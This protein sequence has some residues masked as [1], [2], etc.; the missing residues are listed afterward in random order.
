[1]VSQPKVTVILTSFNHAKYLRESIE[2][3]LAQTYSDFELIIGDDASSDESWEIINSYKDLRIRAFR[4]EKTKGGFII[5]EALSEREIREYVAIHHSDDVWEPDK[6]EK[7]VAFLNENPEVGA[8]FTWA[9]I[10]DEDGN[11]LTDESHFYYKIFE[12]PNRSKYEWLNYFFY[13]GNALCHPSVLIR[14][15]CYEE[16]GVYRPGL[17][18][19]GDFDMWVRLAL[20]HEIHIISEKLVRFRVRQNKTNSSSDNQTTRVRNQF[21]TLQL[22]NHYRDIPSFQELKAIFPEAE[23]YEKGG[24][25][26]IGFILGLIALKETAHAFTEIFGLTL[27]FE[28]INDPARAK[29]L[30]ELYDF[31]QLDFI[32]LSAE[33]DVFST[34]LTRNL[35]VQVIDLETQMA[36]LE[37]Q[38]IH[39]DA[40]TIVL[41]EQLQA[42]KS[43]ETWRILMF[44]HE[45]R[46][47]I[48]HPDILQTVKKK[49]VSL[50]LLP[51][52]PFRK[53]V[54][55][56]NR[57]ITLPRMFIDTAKE[58]GV[59]FSLKKV[60]AK[61]VQF[62]LR[63]G[64]PVSINLPP[65][66]SPIENGF[67]FISHDA[68]ATGAPISLLSQCRAY[69]EVY[70]DDIV[71]VLFA[72]GAL[73]DE[74]KSVGTTICFEQ[75]LSS[76]VVNEEVNTVFAKLKELGYSNCIANTVISGALSE[77]LNANYIET[78]YQL[79]EL[80]GLIRSA[81]YV[82]YAKNIAKSN[83]YI[84]CAANYVAEKFIETFGA[85][86]DSICVIPQGVQASMLYD[87]TKE[88][89]KAKLLAKLQLPYSDDIKIVLGAGVA[90][91]RKGTDLFFRVTERLH[92]MGDGD[93]IHF[94]WVGARDDFYEH[95]KRKILPTLPYKK[96]I[97][98]LDFENDPA[99][100]FAGADLFLL[101]SREDPYPSVAIISIAN[102]TPILMFKNT[103]GIEEILNGTNG[104]AVGHL[105]THEMA[106]EAL[107]I[108]NEKPKGEL[109]K[110]KLITY[111]DYIKA[112]VSLIENKKKTFL[113][114]YK[115]SVIVPN[116]NYEEY[117]AARLQ[118]IIEQTYPPAEIIF[119]DDVSSDNSVA[120]AKE[121]LQNSN[122]PYKVLM[123]QENQGAF[124]QW[125]KGIH[126]AKYEYIWIAEA[127]DLAAKDFLDTL[128]KAFQNK[129]TVLAYCQPMQIDEDSKPY[130][131]Y[132]YADYVGKL[133]ETRWQTNYID[134]GIFEITNYLSVQNTIP[135]VSGV[136]FKK[137]SLKGIEDQLTKYK[138][139]G[140]WFA[141]LYA[142]RSG[143]I[144][145]FSKIMNF[146]RRHR[147]SIITAGD[148]AINFFKEIAEIYDYITDNFTINTRVLDMMEAN[149][150][151]E[152]NAE[153]A[154]EIIQEALKGLREKHR[155]ILNSKKPFEIIIIL[156]EFQIGGGEIT[157]LRLANYLANDHNVYLCA[158]KPD[159]NEQFLEMV[160]PKIHFIGYDR[161]KLLAL[162]RSGKIDIVNSHIWWA[163]KLAYSLLKE[164]HIFW[165][166]SM[167]G[168]YE[169]LIDNPE[170]DRTFKE[171]H[172][173]M[174]AR[175]DFI[176]Y[177][178]A[179]NLMALKALKNETLTNK[180]RLI[181]HG[182]EG[183]KL[184]N[185]VSKESLG[186]AEDSF[187][188]VF[189]ARGIKE[190]GWEE[191]IQSSIS[192]KKSGYNISVILVGDSDYVQK[193]RE[194]YAL[195]FIKFVGKQS[196]LP[197]YFQIADAGLLPTYFVS[198]SQPLIIIEYLAAGLP[199]ISTDI[200]EIK[201]MLHLDGAEAGIVLPL[202]KGRFLEDELEK[203]MKS[204]LLDKENYERL[205][206]TT[207]KIF[208]TKFGIEKFAQA[209][210]SLYIGQESN[211]K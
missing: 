1:M 34:E 207:K 196:N 80:P 50:A 57:V 33:N 137:G 58:Y 140:D 134:D 160:S 141:Y 87:G 170:V 37:T 135:N 149:L 4:H 114:E 99:Y 133:S 131:E 184:L 198:E 187:V 76:I 138:Y 169:M 156:A 25:E 46:T 104:K 92:E 19:I 118:S 23:K 154:E 30:K 42:I 41:E 204:L 63:S 16:C 67:I 123:N 128:L 96:N 15:E 111:T 38:A 205:Q 200:G 172:P 84:V 147:K 101:S 206:Q 47:F 166:L 54:S 83:S 9:N 102:N 157:G 11:P 197:D 178:T 66:L 171:Q 32:K 139:A 116:Y 146:H 211:S 192:M 27:V 71:I 5:N 180:T 125:L 177:D 51:K 105:N 109:S 49:L 112:T 24:R 8:V 209:Y 68:S 12:Q 191:T 65:N 35:L 144:A 122:I 173:S 13:Q 143:Q 194:K 44:L 132:R 10:I 64:K 176:T 36:R 43:S 69:K 20:K 61:I 26:D 108:L 179:K 130:P 100:I 183:G 89:A 136:V 90:H 174:Y 148:G 199:V 127:D 208:D 21:E 18:Q 74:F 150:R 94:L 98:F 91:K 86:E 121:I 201:N 163:D 73:L 7:Q 165:I 97:H 115:V 167:H 72:G 168:C 185:P 6:L 95:W 210:L 56:S 93:N 62:R 81:G 70:G 113:E 22:L 28:A 88:E 142:L 14:K 193:L 126:E 103:G 155:Q 181:Y 107:K 59:V 3:V 175:A 31:T 188:F 189:V 182:Y 75:N 78:I 82:E 162:I 106:L 190:K 85:A 79:H 202:A 153:R 77:V 53:L 152:N 17:T 45:L 164:N 151:G 117:L 186:F 2:S 120:V 40:K 145:Y 48:F 119:L 110:A 203:A 158:A 39:L 195:D 159:Y 52:K 29:N 129:D 60:V 55:Q 124:T 161:Q